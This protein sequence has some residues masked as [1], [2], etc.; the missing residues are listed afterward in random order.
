MGPKMVPKL[1]PGTGP[2][3]DQEWGPDW[4]RDEPSLDQ[5]RGP[6]WTR[7][8]AQPGPGT[9]L[10]LDRDGAWAK[11]SMY[12]YQ[13]RLCM[14]DTTMCVDPYDPICISDFAY[15]PT[16]FGY[17]LQPIWDLIK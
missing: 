4:T 7:D 16:G 17:W 13:M 12:P 11:S 6:A 9:G 8:G 15:I 2:S 10:S 14:D 1:G 5:G 3:L